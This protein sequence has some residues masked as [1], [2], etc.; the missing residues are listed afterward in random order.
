MANGFGTLYIGVSGLQS[1]QNALNI[2]ANNLANVDTN[3]YVRQSVYQADRNYVNFDYTAAISYQQSGLGVAIGDVV[4]T[5]DVF[6]DQSYRTESSRQAFYAATYDATNEVETYF[7]ELEGQA[8]QDTLEDFWVAFQELYNNGPDDSV[9]QNLVIMKA[10][11]LIS[12][13]SSVYS[14]LQ[15]YQYTINTQISDDIDRINELGQTIYDLNQQIMK[16]EAG[17]QETAMTLRDARDL[18]LDELAGL[19]SISYNET[20][21]GMVKVSIEG[22]EFVTENMCYEMGQRT[23][24]VTGFVTPYWEHLSDTSKGKYIDVFSFSKDISAENKNDMGELKALILAR[25]DHVADYRDL[26]GMDQATYN[27]STGMSVMMQSEAELDHLVHNI[28]TSLNDLLCPNVTAGEL[29]SD[30][31]SDIRVKGTTETISADTLVL[32]SANCAVGS[33]GKLPP[34]ELFTRIGTDRYTA[35]EYE[36]EDADG[37]T[38]TGTLYLY[39]EEDLSDDTKMYTLQSL[40]VNANLTDLAS[41]FPHLTQD[42]QVDYDLAAA[43]VAVWDSAQIVLNPNDTKGCGFK[44]YYTSMIG[45]LATDGNVYGSIA[46]S[47][48]ATVSTIDNNRQQ[49]IGVSS[50]EELTYMIKYQNAYNASSRFINV[51][52]EMIET[53]LTS[54]G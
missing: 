39:N 16:I 32:D 44:E 12:R 27:N 30:A 41:L 31:A 38:K 36:Y 21:D 40:S 22:T 17:G 5:R 52:D 19:A 45:E 2:T 53:L 23:D 28:V 51:V 54:L 35:V 26:E 48:E 7:Q 4:H 50:D 11:L 46:D 3:G 20:T 33:D 1:S 24:K 15:S 47:L 25:G 8:F 42:G 14:G 43:L 49:V 37:K 34:Q 13:A 18:A 9:N 6:L 10:G 29:F